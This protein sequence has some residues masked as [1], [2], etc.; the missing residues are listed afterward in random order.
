MISWGGFGGLAHQSKGVTGAR[1]A[2][3][4]LEGLGGRGHS[5]V[6]ALKLFRKK[7]ECGVLLILL[8]GWKFSG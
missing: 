6:G 1:K 2:F 3:D 8:F 5:N 7:T 4:S